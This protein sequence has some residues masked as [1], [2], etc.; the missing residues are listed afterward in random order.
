[1]LEKY[2]G[3][4]L[5]QARSGFGL[6]EIYSAFSRAIGRHIP[7]T[8]A[9]ATAIV[10]WLADYGPFDPKAFDLALTQTL[11]HLGSGRPLTQILQAL[12][13]RINPSQPGKETEL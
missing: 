2:R 8:E 7:S 5:P 6:P 4:I 11:D 9:E 10:Q 12:T 13:R 3:R 1:L